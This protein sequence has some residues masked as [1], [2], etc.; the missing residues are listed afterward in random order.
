MLLLFYLNSIWCTLAAVDWLKMKPDL[1]E[2]PSAMEKTGDHDM[3]REVIKQYWN[4]TNTGTDG[5][6]IDATEHFLWQQQNGIVMELGALSGG[7]DTFS[8]SLIFESFGWRRILIEGNPAYH[9]KTSHLSESTAYVKSAVCDREMK[10]HY[11]QHAL[12]M[13]SGI[14]EFM[15]EKLLEGYFPELYRAAT[16][17]GSGTGDS[18]K[19]QVNMSVVDFSALRR[20]GA[21]KWRFVHCMPL[22]SVLKTLGVQHINLFVLDVEGAELAVLQSIDWDVTRFDVLVIEL[23]HAHQLEGHPVL[24]LMRQHG[25]ELVT[26]KGRNVWYKH[27]DFTLSGRPDVYSG[28][29]RGCSRNHAAGCQKHA[30]RGN[31]LTIL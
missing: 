7:I 27:K 12:P 6:M 29:Y 24:A 17:A 18:G 16:A 9:T 15:D 10:V 30:C 20:S 21:V 26:K 3:F 4:F 22:K 31:Q 14:A 25:Y 1:F 28:C 8:Q 5:E 11:V 19:A 13:V 2:Q 23:N